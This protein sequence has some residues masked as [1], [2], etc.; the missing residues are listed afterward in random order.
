VS[1]PVAAV[2]AVK[3]LQL[4][5]GIGNGSLIHIECATVIGAREVAKAQLFKPVIT[6]VAIHRIVNS[7]VDRIISQPPAAVAAFVAEMVPVSLTPFCSSGPKPLHPTNTI[8]DAV[9]QIMKKHYL[10]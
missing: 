6:L 8:V 9:A 5:S 7:R 3:L 4:D 2:P 1:V 10:F